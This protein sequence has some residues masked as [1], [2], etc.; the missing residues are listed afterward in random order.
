[1]GRARGL[2][3]LSE[4][5]SP[6]WGTTLAVG[7]SCAKEGS[8]E[9]N[10]MTEQIAG[11]DVEHLHGP[12]E[13]SYAEDELAV[14]CLVRDGLPW[15]KSFLEHYFSLGA[16]HLVFLDNGSTD[17]T[18]EALKSYENVTV[19]RTG[20]PYTRHQSLMQRYLI[21]RFGSGR[22]CLCVDMD[23]LFDYPHS[24]V[25]PLG[26]LLGY[27]NAK[28]YTAVMARMLDMFPE[29]LSADRAHELD[30]AW[31]E[32]HRFYDIS[33]IEK[34]GMSDEDAEFRHNV[35][36]SDEVAVRFRGSIRD[37]VFGF[38]KARKGSKY[39][40]VFSDGKVRHFG[41]HQ[42]RNARV[43]DFT[44]VLLHYKFYAF[45]LQEYW[46]KAIEYKKHSKYPTTYEHYRRVLEEGSEV[47][48]KRETSK[49]LF[50]VN[51]LI[52]D[53][54]LVVSDDYVR[55]VEE[56]RN[57]SQISSRQDPRALV[58][59][60]VG[61]K[62]RERAEV[63][64]S[65]RLGQRVLDLEKQVRERGKELKEV[66]KQVREGGEKLK[67]AKRRRQRQSER[68]RGLEGRVGSLRGSLRE[69]QES[70]TWRYTAPL[71]WLV[72]G[73]KRARSR[74]RGGSTPG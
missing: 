44:G 30:D 68:I 53:G 37:E 55:W 50:G 65:R 17:G 74:L 62:R 1:M 19:L 59:A 36:D 40:L 73:A 18:V 8:Y 9:G 10:Q 5:R 47:Q 13:I 27:L 64:R 42:V 52:E 49:E 48:L 14:V 31:Q 58:D 20:L 12:A 7:F 38:S 2:A 72:A 21:E 69:M 57:L 33:G 23:E 70:S 24:D 71:R 16:K 41:P 51:D 35:F 67:A 61:C 43:A 26:S 39:P 45:S 56:E 66:K 11:F 4:L 3:T 28:S 54:F 34:V 32:E 6:A 22:W 46:R 15:V 63:L 60:L 29:R 25:V